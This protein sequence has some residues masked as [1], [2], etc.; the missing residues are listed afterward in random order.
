MIAIRNAG[1]KRMVVCAS[2]ALI[3]ALAVMA[4]G[5]GNPGQGTVQVDPKVA[6]R[7][8]KFRGVAPADY[9]KKTVELIGTKT[10]PRKDRSPK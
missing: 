5:C 2:L 8:G 7:L 1:P 6:A 10:R 4:R 9:G 3:A